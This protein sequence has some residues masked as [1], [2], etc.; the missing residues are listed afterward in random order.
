MNMDNIKNVFVTGATGFIGGHVIRQLREENYGVRA[1]D[2]AS[3]DFS[4]VESL[5]AE[6]RVVDLSDA[7]GLKK[8]C[9]GMD[10]V[11][12]LAGIYDYGA[13]YELL[14]K[15]NV[16]G[17]EN[18]CAAAH[19]CGV[20]KF[21][22]FSTI[23]VYG[24]LQQ[25]PA[26][27]DHPQNPANGYEVTKCEAE[28][29]AMKYYREKNLPVAVV[30]PTLVYG[31]NSKYGLSMFLSV[32]SL[33]AQ[34]KNPSLVIARGGAMTH[35]VR[36]E[37]VARAA[38]FV[39]ENEKTA[40][41]AYHLADDTILT[42]EE[43]TRT[44][45]TPLGVRVRFYIPSWLFQPLYKFVVKPVLRMY[46]EKI[47]H[48]TEKAWNNLIKEGKIVP[49]LRPRL[50]KDWLDYLEAS[51]AFD[52]SKLKSLGFSYRYPDFRQSVLEVIQWYQD[53]KWIPSAIK[54]GGDSNNTS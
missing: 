25:I 40:G 49:A 31:P 37:D 29:I 30:R 43:F 36:V 33:V 27:E 24:R 41:E 16:K 6:K 51:S 46:L 45:M 21:V 7:E 28:R 4:Y 23:G 1:A 11:V 20:K 19:A 9:E 48:M 42:S 13:P 38:A 47:N 12:H 5:G 39:L 44:L 53:N 15:V 18:V 52:N 17:T 32:F 26:R 50:D 54:R 14:E 34:S 3:A 35:C 2:I 22:M 10:A 8:A